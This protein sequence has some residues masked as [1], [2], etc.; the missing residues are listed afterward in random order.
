MLRR[1][2]FFAFCFL[3]I[4]SVAAAQEGNVVLTLRNLNTNEIV[5]DVVVYL[6]LNEEELIR[7]IEGGK[8]L[9]MTLDS[10]SYNLTLGIDDPST[11]GKDYFKKQTINVANALAGHIYLFPV[12][13]LRGIVKDVFDNVVGDA[14]LRFECTDDIG[15]EFPKKTNNFG[16]FEVDY[17]PSCSCKIFANY[18]EAVGFTEVHASQ[19]NMTDVEILLDRTI[20]SIPEPG[21]GVQGFVI[22]LLLVVIILLAAKYKKKLIKKIKQVKKIKQAPAEKPKHEA[23]HEEKKEH[24]EAHHGRAKDIIATLNKKEKDVVELLLSKKEE[25]SQASI[26]HNLGIPRTSLSRILASLE[27]KKIAHI[28]KVGKAVKVRLTDWFIG[29]E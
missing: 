29:K 4:V 11:P 7:Y 13:S 17:M 9:E 18:G 19:G 6:D 12:S 14:E 5:D 21:F 20:L 27:Q 3:I 1:T 22:L 8:S 28:R 25:T 24:K 16:S 26:R 10:G 15:V 2:L 23:K